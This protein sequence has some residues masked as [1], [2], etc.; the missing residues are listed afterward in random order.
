[1]ATLSTFASELLEEAKRFAIKAAETRDASAKQAYLHASLMVGFASFEAHVN[2]IADDFLARTDLTVHERGLL[3]EHAVD[4]KDGEFRESE[5]L[6]V[7]RL[8]DRVLFLCRRFSKTPVDRKQSYWSEFV[9]ASKLRNSLTH[10]KGE[11]VSI[12]EAAVA[13]A[14]RAIVEL[15]NVMYSAI[16]RRKLPAYNRGL[17]SKLNF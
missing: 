10:P 8:E 13:R 9:F 3:A 5:T 4:L 12:S 11:P 1:M 17:S 2:S 6:K 7:Q 16:Y 15:L 14:L